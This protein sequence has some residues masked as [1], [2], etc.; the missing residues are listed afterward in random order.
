VKVAPGGA[1]TN[2]VYVSV[3]PQRSVAMREYLKERGMLISGQ[4]NIR[5]VTHLDV[6]RPDIDRFIGAV[7]EFFAQAA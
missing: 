2:M 7:K 5:L 3:E 4:G 1:R 6:D